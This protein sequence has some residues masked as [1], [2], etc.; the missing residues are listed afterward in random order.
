MTA[1]NP[2]PSQNSMGILMSVMR[3]FRY[4]PRIFRLLW[5]SHRGYFFLVIVLNVIKGMIPAVLIIATERLISAVQLA[6]Q[7]GMKP[8]LIV[9]AVFASLA[10]I[11][12]LV[13]LVLESYQSLYQD[14]L[15]NTVNIKLMEKAVRLPFASFE[16]AE[17]YD[18]LQRARQDSSY[19]PY[20]IF[21]Q[22]MGVISGGV[23]L[24]S[25]AG[26]LVAWKWW[27]A[28]IVL[29]IPMMS[30]I[31]FLKLGEQVFLVN[32][33][34][35]ADRR[36]QFY[37]LHLLTTDSTVKEIKILQLGAHIVRK[38]REF[39]NTFFGQ[40]KRLLMRRMRLSLFFQT[41][42]FLIVGGMQ[43]FV[44]WETLVGAIALGS[45]IA[46]I[47]AISLTQVTSYVL[48]QTVFSMYQNNLYISQLFVFL[49]VP[50]TEN[51][52][53]SNQSVLIEGKHRGLEFRN[54]SFRYQGMSQYALKN[55]SFALR[56]GENLAIVG[57]NGSGKSTLVK[58]I[59]RLY[60]PTEGEILFE[61][62][63]IQSYDIDE[64]RS[65]IG[66][67][68]QDFV[69][70]EL[71][72]RENIAY[73]DWRHADDEAAIQLAATRSGADEVIKH[74]PQGMDTQLGRMFADGMQLSGGQWQKIAIARA[75]MRDS[76]LYILDEPTAALDPASETE[77]FERFR[78]LTND[79]MGLYITH[80]YSTVRYASS[81][82]VL[83]KG[84]IVEIGTHRQLMDQRGVYATLFQ[85][86][87]SSYIEND[88]RPKV[89]EVV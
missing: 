1:N 58:L 79:K 43:L 60:E 53:V 74:L 23:T 27:L 9:F 28:L 40:D 35:A 67:V 59:A 36:K 45:L 76:D 19:R 83:E 39:Y 69:R 2:A 44:V 22:V 25:V 82:M 34:R 56:P 21:Q 17:I 64:W 31:S 3:S 61:G 85:M 16:N 77:V 13:R 26:V 38:Y 57:E 47:Q 33:N 48:M 7:Q 30:A 71:T 18:N 12:E 11:Q 89:A 62:K 6:P 80:R 5:E 10:L 54:V 87:A 73:G 78:E 63:P 8:A 66:A 55:V 50:E 72:V 14:L 68:F 15:S 86:Q 65:K 52:A 70:Y 88:E 41:V 20:Q 84:E 81:I 75:Y 24:I 37:F 49:D 51:A 46:Y 32:Y 29:C 42:T 4:W